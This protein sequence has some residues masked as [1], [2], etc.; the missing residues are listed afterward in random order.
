M[1]V[2]FRWVDSDHLEAHES[3]VGLY[4]I[5]STEADVLLAAI[6][7]VLLKFNVSMKKLRGQCYDG[8]APMAGKRQG[9]AKQILVE[10]PRALYTHCYGHSLNHACSD[11]INGCSV[12]KKTLEISYEII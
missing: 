2:C 4:E 5:A 12:M 1:V 7:D 3:F 8:A 11:A 10:E 6:R 9:V